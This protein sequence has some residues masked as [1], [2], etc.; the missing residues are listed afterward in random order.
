MTPNADVLTTTPNWMR[1]VV[2]AGLTFAGLLLTL[3]LIGEDSSREDKTTA[4]AILSSGLYTLVLARTRR[5]WLPRLSSHPLRSAMIL[6]TVNAAVIEMLF[7]VV[8]KLMGAEGVSADPNLLLDLLITMPW[9]VGMVVIFV[10]VQHRRRFSPWTVLWLGGLYEVGGDGLV[11]GILSGDL[12]NP[13]TPLLI[14]GVMWWVFIPVY[15][16]MV[17]PPAW[18]IE[19]T[20]PIDPPPSPAWQDA[21]RPL[22]WL[23][24][25]LIYVQVLLMILGG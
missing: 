6:G 11:G 13:L 12:F 19:M 14:I 2:L 9:Y 16:S 3:M 23:I 5:W 17:L 10:W 21:L 15:S 20:P 18:L 8:E 22:L 1:R 24:P 4:I 25:F 7:L